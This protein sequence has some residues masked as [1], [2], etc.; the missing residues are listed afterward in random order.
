MTSDVQRRALYLFRSPPLCLTTN[1]APHTDVLNFI[2][3]GVYSSD[4][5]QSCP[6]ERHKVS[7]HRQVV[8]CKLRKDMRPERND[9]LAYGSTG[10][11]PRARL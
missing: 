6:D 5:A 7:R 8:S 9:V 4:F 10:I 2:Y 1:E 3:M 11:L